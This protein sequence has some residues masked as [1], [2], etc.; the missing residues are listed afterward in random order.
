[1]KADTASSTA[2]TVL[3]GVLMTARDPAYAGQVAPATEQACRQILQASPEGRRRLKT[4]DSGLA[5]RIMPLAERLIMPGIAGHYVMRKRFMEEAALAALADGYTQVVCLGAG[6]DVL[7]LTLHRA[8]PDATFIEIDHPATSAVKQAAIAGTTADNLHLLAVD[9]AERSLP[10]A[11]GG[12]PA[13][14]PG[15]R[16]LFLCEGVLMYLDV[17]AVVALFAAIRDLTGPGSRFGF[18][19]VTPMTSPDNNT[20]PLLRAYLAIKREP[21]AWTLERP[22]IAGFVAARDY[23][24]LDSANTAD[25]VARY[26]SRPVAGPIHKGEFMALTEAC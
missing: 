2:F 14:D 1:M 18:T 6:F 5:R 15:R 25:L 10:A 11:L 23:R 7:A 8:W 21:L 12:F 3:Q 13:F 22:Q 19:A 20:G 4:V 17:S 26:M 16:T 24:L 9:L